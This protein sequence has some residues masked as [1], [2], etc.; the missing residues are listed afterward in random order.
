MEAKDY[1]NIAGTPFQPF[2]DKQIEARKKLIAKEDRSSK[3][4]LWL[5]NRNAWI[6]ISSGTSVDD[7]NQLFTEV[8]DTLSRKYILQAGLTDHSKVSNQADNIFNLRGGLS[9]NGAYGIGGTKEFGYR[10]MPGLTGLSIKTGGKLGTLREATFEFTCYNLEQLTIMDALYMKLGFSVLIEWGHIPYINNDGNLQVNPLP[11]DF[12]KLTSKEQLM[13]EIQK[14]RVI[15]SGNYDAMW[16]TIKNFS[17]SFGGNGE[18]KCKVDLVGAGDI[19]ESLKINQSG[20]VGKVSSE[21][22]KEAIDKKEESPYPVIANQ[23]ES[24]LN[25]VLFKIFTKDVTTESPEINWD[26]SNEYFNMINPYFKKLNISFV[27]NPCP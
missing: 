8:G 3:D 1:T 21:E 7:T 5:N 18:F 15:H 16:G 13:E 9:P 25:E 27:T 19:L 22:E 20:T 12:Y 10:P 6:R 17:Y 14:R 23:N 24:F 2:V 26:Y 11:M 4:L